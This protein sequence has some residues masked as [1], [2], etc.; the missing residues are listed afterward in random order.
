MKITPI[1]TRIFQPKEK[2]LPF[3]K[4]SLPRLRER[5]ILVVTS[6]IVA[7][8]EGRFLNQTDKKT[9]ERLIKSESSWAT[10]TKHVWLTIKDGAFMAA[11]GIDESNAA[12]RLI[13][14]PQDSFRAAA[15]ICHYFKKLYRLKNLGVIIT[16]SRCL[17]LR[18]GITGQALGYA[19]FQGIKDYRGQPDLFG[20]ILKIS[21]VNVADSLATA[22]VLTMG[23]G[24]ER[25][26]LAI[27]E[28]APVKFTAKTSRRELA[29]P[30]TD[31]IFWPLL[32]GIRVK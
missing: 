25:Q 1:K 19:G 26:P 23:E 10:P 22:A 9:K 31:D 3:L 13:L 16:D 18:A 15:A 30:P 32:K 8:A 17:P 24:R 12:G 2:L 7:L 5:E 29:I 27:I 6:K 20:R 4:K 14:L 21:Q 11:A 28:A